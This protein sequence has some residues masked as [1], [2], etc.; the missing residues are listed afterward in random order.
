[1]FMLRDSNWALPGNE[2]RALQEQSDQGADVKQSI[3]KAVVD[4]CESGDLG[5]VTCP[6]LQLVVPA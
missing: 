6:E 5:V 1:M 4:A 2:V 3:L